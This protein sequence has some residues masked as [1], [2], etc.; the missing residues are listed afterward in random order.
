[1]S[2]SMFS[3]PSRCIGSLVMAHVRPVRALPESP[4]E[5]ELK[6]ARQQSEAVLSSRN[7]PEDQQPTVLIFLH[8]F[9][10]VATAL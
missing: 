3:L 5:V 6:A 8:Y 4:D 1:M 9:R 2:K 10:D 7:I